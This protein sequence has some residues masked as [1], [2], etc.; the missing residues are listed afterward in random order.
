MA[1]TQI[2]VGCTG[3]ASEH[4]RQHVMV[5]PS[6]DA[7]KEWLVEM[8][9]VLVNVGWTIVFVATRVDVEAVADAVRKQ[10]PTLILET[11]HGDKHPTDRHAALKAFANGKVLVLVATDV[12]S[13]GLDISNVSTV[14]NFD[15]AK[16]LDVHTHRVGRAGRLAK[17]SQE[18]REGSAYTLLTQKNADFANVLMKAFEREGRNVTVELKGLADKCKRAGNVDSRSKWNKAGLGFNDDNVPASASNFYGP[19]S[20]EHDAPPAKK[21]RWS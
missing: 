20:G 9:P 4:V 7:K 5:L 2:S 8:L 17:D 6:Y 1:D 13:R 15:A 18:H 19:S 11:L 12:A 10:N 14:I 16:N 3:E 21:S